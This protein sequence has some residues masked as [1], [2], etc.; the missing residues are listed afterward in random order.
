MRYADFCGKQASVIALGTMD[1]SVTIEESKAFDFMDAY[2]ALG[3]NFLDTARLYGNL[4]GERENDTERV[5][6]D[7]LSARGSRGSI[8][9]STK[10]GHPD[11]RTKEKRLDRANVLR[12]M[13][14]SL[15]HLQTDHVDIYWLHRDDPER[16]VEEILTTLTELVERGMTKYVGVSNWTARRIAE[17]NEAARAHGLVPIYADQPQFSLARQVHIED[18][19]LVQMDAELHALHVQTGMPCVCFTSQAKGFLSKMA[20]GGEAALSD[21]AKRRYLCAENLALLERT[22]EIARR[23]G[24]SVNAAALSYL[25]GQPFPCFPIAGASKLEQVLA[26]AEAGDAVLSPEEVAYLR[27]F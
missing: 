17:A 5:V 22:E 16:S 6:G 11:L 18:P 24:I 19:T 13:Q 10:G 7:W 9:L 12:D 23:R 14:T 15:E 3:G 27:G 26:I 25:T 21:K 20:A 2:A 8:I 4:S 1:F